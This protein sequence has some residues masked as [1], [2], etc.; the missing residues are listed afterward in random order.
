MRRPPYSGRIIRGVY[1][2]WEKMKQNIANGYVPHWWTK[3]DQK[4]AKR[5]LQ[6]LGDF[7]DWVTWKEEGRQ[8]VAEA[9]EKL[10]AEA[11]ED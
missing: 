10:K 9:L 6:W 3:Q 2:I 8:K 7:F 11:K 4:D 1:L 5:A